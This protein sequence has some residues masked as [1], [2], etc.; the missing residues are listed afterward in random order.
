MKFQDLLNKFRQWDNRSSQWFAR[1]FYVLFF[2][3]ILIAVF[4]FFFAN[5]INMINISA[6]INQN[7][8]LERLLQAQNIS[9]LLILFLAIINSFLMLFLFSGFLRI[10][11]ILKNIDFNLSKRPNDRRND[12]SF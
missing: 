6:D 11:S 12:D 1:H 4:F 8:I 7:T 10:R 9:T 3:A 5:I 2:E